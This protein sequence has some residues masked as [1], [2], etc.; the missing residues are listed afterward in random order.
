DLAARAKAPAETGG[1]KVLFANGDILRG[2]LAGGDGESILLDV[3]GAGRLKLPRNRLQSLAVTASEPP[4]L[5]G[6]TGL[7]GWTEVS[8]PIQGLAGVEAGHWTY[9][10]GAFYAS[11]PA[12]IAR[13]LKL[14]GMMRMEFD[15]AWRGQPNLA[16]ALYTD[17]LRPI[18]LMNKESGPD[19]GAFY[20]FRLGNIVADMYPI[21]KHGPSISLGSVI[22]AALGRADHAHF[23]IRV[24]KPQN[25]IYLLV[26]GVLVMQWS[27]PNGFEGEG[28]GVRFVENSG[29][30]KLS[31]LRVT[32]WDGIL[33]EKT[34]N[35]PRGPDD[36]VW[37]ND[38]QSTAGAITAI[39]PEGV[40]IRVQN[41][42]REIPFASIRE[43]DFGAPPVRPTLEGAGGVRATFAEGGCIH[44]LLESW[45]ADGA[46]FRSP[47]FGRAKF[48][49]SQ[50]AALQFLRDEGNRPAA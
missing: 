40:S 12:S 6:I 38:G 19:F 3:A 7:E 50:F 21:K 14:P 25:K 10:N 39:N 22:L 41:A 49:P 30:I 18:L 4:L 24:S 2:S 27:D 8:S 13:D 26:D 32:R 37:L 47:D 16:I 17:S 33:E 9:R 15:L 36:V 20:S 34:E 45:S 44:G 31:N 1:C 46:V 42:A 48:N 11:K 28:T 43:I 5:D 35:A 23:D 29:A